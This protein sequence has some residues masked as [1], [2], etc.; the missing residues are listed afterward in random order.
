MHLF[1]FFF[2]G[3]FFFAAL[4]KGA[5]IEEDSLSL[6]LKNLRLK[7]LSA[8]A[9]EDKTSLNARFTSTL[10]KSLEANRNI[11][12]DS[13]PNVSV[14]QDDD[15][16]IK[17]ISWNIVYSNERYYYS[18][19]LGVKL[20]KEWT[21]YVLNDQ[22]E[23]AA[24]PLRSLGTA[25]SWYGMLYYDIIA[26]GKKNQKAYLLLAWDGNSMHST[27]KIIDVLWLDDEG[28]PRFGKK[29]FGIPYEDQHRVVF[30]YSKDAVMSLKYEEKNQRVVFDHLSPL[31]TNLEG[32]YEFYVPDLS[33]DALHFKDDK[34]LLI[35]NIDV[36]GNQSMDNYNAPPPLP[37]I[38]K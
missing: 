20:K 2:V 17:L 1:K 11:L 19:I 13:I 8:S 15:K 38:N 5:A 28:I 33:F 37:G 7:S 6:E 18:G 21:Y 30:E 10:F 16:M 36:R 34:W 4:V 27:K 22:S 31:Q 26:F 32:M 35:Q 14:L 12:F 9:D 29:V 3:L 25:R 24:D 23:K